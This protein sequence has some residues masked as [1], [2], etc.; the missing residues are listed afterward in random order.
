[1]VVSIIAHRAS[2]EY[3]APRAR[4]DPFIHSQELVHLLVPTASHQEASHRLPSQCLPPHHT[5]TPQQAAHQ[6]PRQHHIPRLRLTQCQTSR[7]SNPHR[8]QSRS[9]SFQSSIGS[10]SCGLSLWFVIDVVTVSSSSTETPTKTTKAPSG[11]DGLTTEERK[12]RNEARASYY[13][14]LG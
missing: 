5:T 9:I 1:M 4:D 10:V 14:T 12:I 11:K 2:I 6:R 7:P 13:S 3:P 8:L